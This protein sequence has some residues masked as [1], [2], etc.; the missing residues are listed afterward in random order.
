MTFDI[1]KEY[2]VNKTA[3]EALVGQYH[4]LDANIKKAQVNL[5]AIKVEAEKKNAVVQLLEPYIEKP[6][7]EV[8]EAAKDG[9]T[10]AEKAPEQPKTD[11]AV[12]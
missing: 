2:T 7:S 8:V 6:K 9:A 3:L 4:E 1:E 11:A 5:E 12:A 10:D